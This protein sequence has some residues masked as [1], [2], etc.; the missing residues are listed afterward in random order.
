MEKKLYQC[1][2]TVV[3]YAYA[4]SLQEA[5]SLR[6]QVLED[7]SPPVSEQGGRVIDTAPHEIEECWE[8]MDIVYTKE[9]HGPSLGSC[10]SDLP[11]YEVKWKYWEG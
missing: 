4:E 7:D 10:L 9:G 3:W 8:P 6:A 1:H 11:R 5:M 2:A